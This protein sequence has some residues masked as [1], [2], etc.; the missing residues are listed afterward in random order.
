MNKTGVLILCI[1]TGIILSSVCSAQE[2]NY[3]IEVL[4]VT[5]IEPYQQAY[6]SF[7]TELEKGGLA[8]GRNLTVNRAIL[9][10]DVEKSGLW[11][12]IGV[13]MRIKRETS[14]I[15]GVK[16]DLVLTI[17]TP[18]TKYSRDK[19]VEAGIPLVFTAVAIPEAAGC[20]SLTEGGKGCTGA[21]LY[22]NMK[23]ALQIVRLAFP[24]IATVAII[25]S[26]DDNALAHVEEAKKHGPGVGMTF[27]SKEVGKSESITT[28]VNE[29]LGQGVQAFAIPLDTY[30]GLRDYEETKKL[31]QIS[32]EQKIPIFSFVLGKVPGALLYVGSDFSTIGG[33]SGRQAV[34]ILRDGSDPSTL[35]ILRQDDLNILVDTNQVKALGVNLPM[36]ILQLAKDVD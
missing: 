3:R 1:V 19:I 32:L 26:D 30:Y 31:A 2:K 34:K 11:S 8:Q 5:A 18:A 36:E 7:L 20:P 16:P 24:T 15:V 35:P 4:Q 6:E 14:R 23:D 12:K 29:L 9:D 27:L 33:L 10:F 13:L 25:H 22:M 28:A 17:G 21:T